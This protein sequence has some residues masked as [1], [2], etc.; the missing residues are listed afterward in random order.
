MAAAANNNL[1]APWGVVAAPTGFG[2]FAGDI[3]VGNFGDG[4]ISAFD[5]T[6][7]FVGQLTDSSGK[8][9]V[10]PGLW[11]MVF[12]GGGG[13]NNDPGI[14]RHSLHNRRRQRGST[15]FSDAVAARP[16]YSLPCARGY[17]RRRILPEPFCHKH[18]CSCGGVGQPYGHAAAV[19]GFNGQITLTCSAPAGLSCALSP[20]TISPGS[21]AASS[22]LTVSADSTPPPTGYTSSSLGCSSSYPVWAY[23]ELCSPIANRNRLHAKDF[24]G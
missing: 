2:T 9:L 23:S 19:G 7:K 17:G 3:L 21:S 6:G 24:S 15:Q 20:S 8:V 11:D 4:T 14:A 22:T 12:G 13:A 18:H 10:N 5:T 16:L 1:N